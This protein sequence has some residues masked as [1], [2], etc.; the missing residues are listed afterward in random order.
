MWNAESEKVE[1][2]MRN[3]E[4]GR[5]NAEFKELKLKYF[6]SKKAVPDFEYHCG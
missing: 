1:V 5:R 3:S 6:S 4:I 2:G